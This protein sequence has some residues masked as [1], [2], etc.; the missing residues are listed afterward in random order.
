[1][2]KRAKASTLEV[3]KKVRAAIPDFQKLLPPALRSA[4]SSTQTPVVKRAIGDLVKEGGLGA[5]LTGLMVLLFLRDPRSALIVIINI[6]LSLLASAFG[7]WITGQ[8]IH[9][10][11]LGGMALAVGILVDEATVTVENI[12]THLSRR[13]SMARAALDGTEETTLPRLLAMLCILA[14]FIPA[15]FMTGAAK[16]LFV[17]LALAVGFAMAASFVLSSTLVPVLSVWFL[18]SAAIHDSGKPGP[19]T[20]I[21]QGSPRRRSRCGGSSFRPISAVAR[22]WCSPSARS[23]A[24]RFSPNQTLAN[25]H[26][27]SGHRAERRSASPKGSPKRSSPRS[28]GKPAVRTRSR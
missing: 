9:L 16:A 8:N 6:P 17:P 15:F 20:R 19:L 3:V 12:H 2:T 23:S 10:V 11:T 14:V 21:Y 4:S 24:R 7:L 28:P 22:W 25:S 13:K 26:F 5:L 1:V 27:V 18:R